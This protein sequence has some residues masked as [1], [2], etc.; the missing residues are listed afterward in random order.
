MILSR[1]RATTLA[2]IIVTTPF[3][4][5]QSKA[6]GR[7]A[8]TLGVGVDAR[9]H[10]GKSDA[11]K[12]S[13]GPEASLRFSTGLVSLGVGVLRA[14]D[15]NIN[16]LTHSLH[17]W[18]VTTPFAEVRVQPGPSTAYLRPVVFLRGGLARRATHEDFLVQH[19]WSATAGA[20]LASSLNPRVALMI[21][22][23][24]QA[25][26]WSESTTAGA[27]PGQAPSS[28]LGWVTVFVEL[29]LDL[30]AGARH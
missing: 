25:E 6:Q 13:Y 2:L 16:P 12:T 9:Q 28:T 18:L 15:R 30:R 17:D 10:V 7:G 21:A 20:G 11:A 27:A 29:S 3:L 24:F 4:A 14:T 1:P 5:A 26:G 23:A 19:G 8:I 22:A